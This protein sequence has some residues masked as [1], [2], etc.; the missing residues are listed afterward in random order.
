FKQQDSPFGGLIMLGLG[1]GM[2]AAG[3]KLKNEHLLHAGYGG[4]AVGGLVAGNRLVSSAGKSG[5]FSPILS[6]LRARFGAVKPAPRD[7]VIMLNDGQANFN[8][9]RS[10]YVDGRSANPLRLGRSPMKGRGYFN[11]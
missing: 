6:G 4:T 2:I 11:N 9:V 10:D 8:G 3:T 1:V 5:P 7:R